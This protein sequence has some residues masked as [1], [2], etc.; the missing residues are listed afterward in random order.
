MEK[1]LTSSQVSEND[2]G[3][4]R[5]KCLSEYQDKEFAK[6][7]IWNHPQAFSSSDGYM[8]F[9]DLSDTDSIALSFV[10]DI[11]SELNKE[12]AG[13]TQHKCS[14]KFVSVRELRLIES[15]L[16]MSGM[17]RVCNSLINEHSLVSELTIGGTLM[18]EGSVTDTGV[19]SLCEALQHASCK[20]T[21]LNLWE[22]ITDTGVASLCEALQ[23]PSCKLT[24]LNLLS[25]KI[26]DTGATSLSEALQHSSCK[27]TTLS[28][29]H[30]KITD[31]GVASLCEGLQHSSC[32]LTTLDLSY[33]K[34]T[35]TGVSSLC[36]ALQHPSCKLTTLNQCGTEITDT[37]VASLS[38]S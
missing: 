1:L 5:A 13:E 22:N 36:E 33:N 10:L 32:N 6:T 31:T 14:D 7:F 38:K 16:T 23:H 20:L 3:L 27:L 18:I 8:Y 12:E 24:T 2:T 4:L 34:I 19:A 28:L 30:N 25:D 17:Q 9:N 26:T 21:T 11:I 35:D 37:G 29:K 15:H